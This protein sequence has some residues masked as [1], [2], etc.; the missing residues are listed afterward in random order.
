[1]GV[2]LG[3]VDAQADRLLAVQRAQVDTAKLLSTFAAGVAASVVGTALQVGAPASGRLRT[4]TI[5]L[6][7]SVLLIIPVILADRI[8]VVDHKVL[9]AEATLRSWTEDKFQLEYRLA[10]LT[11]VDENHIFVRLVKLATS[12][13][14]LSA[15]ASG[16]LA[17]STLMR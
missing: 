9:L 4:A 5:V 6:G 15:F 2:S 12:A 8:R 14:L 16:T 13:Q 1:M 3:W 17:A 10:A 7:I 11:A